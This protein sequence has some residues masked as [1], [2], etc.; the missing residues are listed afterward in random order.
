MYTI[1]KS[2]AF[3]AAHHLNGLP[4][5]HQCSRSHG[6]SYRVEVELSA[7]YLNSASF[8]VDYG[9]LDI[10][11]KYLKHNFDHRDLNEIRDFKEVPIQ[12]SAENLAK[13]FY[14]WCVAAWPETTAV[15]VSETA[16][17]WAEYRP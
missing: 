15:R 14:D 16:R 9:D 11:A 7:W 3:E 13:Y 8:V 10:F 5:E 12:T 6:H 2:F 1:T 4:L 17:S